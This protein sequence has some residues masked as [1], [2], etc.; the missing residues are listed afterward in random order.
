MKKIAYITIILL[1]AGCENLFHEDENTIQSIKSEDEL[2]S[3]L[4]AAYGWLAKTA[5]P[6]KS[7]IQL[8]NADDINYESDNHVNLNFTFDT[9]GIYYTDNCNRG[10]MITHLYNYTGFNDYE[11]LNLTLW[12]ELYKSIACVNNI[13]VQYSEPDIESTDTKKLLGE[14]FFIR[15]YCY[16]RLVRIYGRIPLVNDIDV[17]YTLPRA[18]FEEIYNFIENDLLKAIAYLPESNYQARIPYVTSHRG[19]AKAFLAEVYLTMG[20]FPLHDNEK[21]ALAARVAGE[22]IDSAHF[23]GFELLP[24]YADLWKHNCLETTFFSPRYYCPDTRFNAESVFASEADNNSSISRYSTIGTSDTIFFPLLI[25]QGGI[26]PEVNFYNLFPESYRKEVTY[27]ANMV[28]GFQLNKN[29]KYS[30]FIYHFN[31]ISTCYVGMNFKKISYTEFDKDAE[32]FDDPL[33]AFID[34]EY[35]ISRG[36]RVQYL[37]R[38]AH[39]LLTFAEAKARSGQLDEFAYEAVN[40]IRR[41]ANKVDLYSASVYDLPTGLTAAQFADSVVQERAWEFACENEGRWFDLLRLEKV[42]ELPELRHPLEGGPPEY[43]IT[44]DCYFAPI[45]D[46]DRWLNPNL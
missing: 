27:T 33:Q 24:D 34:N 22:V 12:S 15:A 14:A 17:N 3:A 10:S 29:F 23:Y 2:I 35:Y 39:T 32:E 20:G 9:A 36:I 21:Y 7:L 19:T 16:Y 8:I 42:D 6:I 43:P 26:I 41:R 38:F 28:I 46:E 4:N 11:T 25:F 40:R 30:P 45:P 31:D 1:F 44:E 13:I 5:E 37:L 18:S